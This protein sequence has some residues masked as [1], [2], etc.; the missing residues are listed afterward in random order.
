MATADRSPADPLDERIL[1]AAPRCIARWGLTKTTLDDL[2]REAGCSR[3]SIYRHF[4]GG[5]DQVLV[6]ALL[7]E[8]ARL[9]GELAPHLE[10]AESLED[11]LV[12]GLSG[13]AR[14]LDDNEALQYLMDHEPEVVLPHIAFDRVGPMLHR[15]SAFAGPYLERFLAP[16]DA[17]EVAQWVTRLLLSYTL[18]PS[19]HV[20]LR[21]PDQARRFVDTFVLPAINSSSE[22][23]GEPHVIH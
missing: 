15:V 1:A 6:A 22:P 18:R 16:R 7:Y 4:P 2:A 5:K 20:D 9:F 12:I 19:E 10:A 13:A 23:K 3:A 17:A 8:E 21:Q 14:F 11:L